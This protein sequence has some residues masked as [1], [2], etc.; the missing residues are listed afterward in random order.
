MGRLLEIAKRALSRQM[1]APATKTLCDA[2]QPNARFVRSERPPDPCE[3][4]YEA[5]L[6]DPLY[7]GTLTGEVPHGWTRDGWIISLKDRMTRTDD[8][9]MLDMLNRELKS[10]SESK[11]KRSSKS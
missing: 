8:P 1:V 4:R 5:P 9:V 6:F 11:T 10:V 2:T 7:T 3:I